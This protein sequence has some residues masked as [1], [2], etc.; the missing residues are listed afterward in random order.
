MQ[1]LGSLLI[2][3]YFNLSWLQAGSITSTVESKEILRGE[4]VLLSIIIVG[5][6]FD[7][8]PDIPRIGG[9]KILG[10]HRSV[11]TK[12]MEKQLWSRPLF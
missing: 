7:T 5:E 9:A 8:L 3:I 4:S 1:I 6:K 12:L 2:L 10:S 11:Q